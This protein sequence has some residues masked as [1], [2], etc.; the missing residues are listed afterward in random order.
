MLTGWTLLKE[1][2]PTPHLVVVAA[3]PEEPKMAK[4]SI[5]I[6]HFN[7]QDF[8]EDTLNSILEQTYTQYEVVVVDDGSTDP[9]ARHKLR[10][11]T[12]PNVTV[13]FE[14]HRHIAGCRNHGIRHTRSEY[15]L[16]LDADDLIHPDFLQSAVEVLDSQPEVGVVSSWIQTFGVGRWLVKPEGGTV[17][18]FLHKNNCPG[19]AL[20]RR[21]S[22]QKAGGYKEQLKG[23]FEDWDLYLSITELGE[24]IHILPHPYLMYRT[25]NASANMT[26]HPVRLDHLRPIIELHQHTYQKHLLDVLLCKEQ[27]LIQ[28]R[29]HLKHLL[30]EHHLPLPEVTFGDGGMAFAVEVESAR[31]A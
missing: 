14:P 21:S 1:R 29:Q 4:V 17:V 16:V 18:D 10:S 6:P 23:H 20:I 27:Q 8:I 7:H 15:L 26:N 30:I 28:Q 12:C 13:H 2:P 22:W 24:R 9:R 11:L 3:C 25:R 31:P 19:S 5:I